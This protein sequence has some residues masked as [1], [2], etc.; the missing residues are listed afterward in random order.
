MST[1]KRRG[2]RVVSRGGTTAFFDAT[3]IMPEV[4]VLAG[5]LAA[6]TATGCIWVPGPAGIGWQLKYRHSNCLE[7]GHGHG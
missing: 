1:R 7:R 3:R 2:G 6:L 4:P 5:D